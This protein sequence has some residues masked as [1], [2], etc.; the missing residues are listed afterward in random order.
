MKEINHETR[1]DKLSAGTKDT[2]KTVKYDFDL[3]SFSCS[4][5]FS[6]L[7]RAVPYRRSSTTVPC[8][9]AAVMLSARPSRSSRIR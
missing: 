7:I 2:K 3:F 1:F 6:W 8:Q 4:P 5:C 9:V